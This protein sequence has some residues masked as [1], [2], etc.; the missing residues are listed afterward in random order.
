V[1]VQKRTATEFIS[2]IEYNSEHKMRGEE[3]R[4]AHPLACMDR[5][6]QINL[7]ENP[8]GK[9]SLGRQRGTRKDNVKMDLKK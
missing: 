2:S 1:V 9:R 6:T 4:L 5:T 8:E 3:V 7:E